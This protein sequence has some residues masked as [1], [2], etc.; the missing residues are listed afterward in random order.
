MALSPSPNCEGTL[1]EIAG[2]KTE[3]KLAITIPGNLIAQ[4]TSR[5][6]FT[7]GIEFHVVPLRK[8]SDGFFG[9][10][11]FLP[12]SRYNLFPLPLELVLVGVP[13]Q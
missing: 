6:P 11:T 4:L 10:S 12:A 5:D 2:D 7:H 3:F 1:D 9:R 8:R 13:E